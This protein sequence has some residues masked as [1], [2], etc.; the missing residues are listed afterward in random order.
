[1]VE[2]RADKAPKSVDNFVQYVNAGF[3]DGTIFHRVISGFMIQGGGYDVKGTERP[4]SPPIENESKNGVSNVRG[5]IAMARTGDAGDKK[6][7]GS[8][9]EDGAGDVE[10]MLGAARLREGHRAHQC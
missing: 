8:G 6:A 5:T 2:L 3:Y 4:T 9:I 1:M 7:E 10:A